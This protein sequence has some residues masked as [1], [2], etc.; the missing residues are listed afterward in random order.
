[1]LKKQ[2]QQ[3][4]QAIFTKKTHKVFNKTE[5]Q[6]LFEEQ[7]SQIRIRSYN[8]T[9]FINL[10]TQLSIL[11]ECH[12]NF[13]NN[14]NSQEKTKYLFDKPDN[15][16]LIYG[17]GK[18]PYLSFETALFYHGL[19]KKEPKVNSVT[20][21]QS[22]KKSVVKVLEQDRINHAFSQEAKMSNTIASY[23]KM[24]WIIHNGMYTGNIGLCDF[25]ANP[26]IKITDLERT[27][28]DVTVRATFVGGPEKVLEFYKKVKGRISTQNLLSLLD[29]INY[30]YPYHQ[31]IGFYLD[32]AGY[33]LNEYKSFKEI[34]MRYD[35]YLDYGMEENNYSE[36]WKVYYP[37]DLI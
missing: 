25:G 36:K 4:F 18:N 23:G 33:D 31:A 5:L 6:K 30:T 11:K 26:N 34:P 21:E 27:I 28:L 1:M 19:L 16:E 17:L 14:D 35:F 9:K 13:S 37:S 2:Y 32:K 22:F 15:N 12:F 3:H 10:L 20:I 8:L 7:K 24:K 29:Q